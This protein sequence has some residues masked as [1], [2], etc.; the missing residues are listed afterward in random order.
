MRQNGEI[1]KIHKIHAPKF[2]VRAFEK[3]N[4]CGRLI[5]HAVLG[6]TL[7]SMNIDKHG[8]LLSK[9]LKLGW[10]TLHGAMVATYES[11]GALPSIITT[12]DRVAGSRQH[13][14][15]VNAMSA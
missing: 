11:K 4:A 9:D 5:D 13:T 15:R 14:T 3:K 8:D 2:Q 6:G 12:H 1:D 10:G 7:K